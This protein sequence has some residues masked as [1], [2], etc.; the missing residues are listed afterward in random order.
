MPICSTIRSSASSMYHQKSTA[1][2]WWRC[3]ALIHLRQRFLGSTRC[4]HRAMTFAYKREFCQPLNF[5]QITLRTGHTKCGHFLTDQMFPIKNQKLTSQVF[6]C[7]QHRRK[8]ESSRLKSR[9]AIFSS[10]EGIPEPTECNGDAT[11]IFFRPLYGLSE[12]NSVC[13][14]TEETA[15]DLER[16]KKS[17][18]IK[19]ERTPGVHKDFSV[20]IW[21]NK[22]SHIHKASRFSTRDDEIPSV[23][24]EPLPHPWAISWSHRQDKGEGKRRVM[25]AGGCS[26]SL[27]LHFLITYKKNLMV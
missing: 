14:P 4:C 1:G 16:K 24:Q 12:H 23:T 18:T 9:E 2:A 19:S 20:I 13:K 21:T 3:T 6:G 25:A 17:C 7:R 10:R 26:G 27:V 22:E 5:P 8:P 11:S 15:Q